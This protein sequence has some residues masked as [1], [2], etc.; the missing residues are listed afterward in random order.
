[1]VHSWPN[2]LFHAF[3][4]IE[5]GGYR[6]IFPVRRFVC[7]AVVA[8]PQFVHTSRSLWAM[9]DRPRPV[10]RRLERYWETQWG[11]K[12]NVPLEPDVPLRPNVCEKPT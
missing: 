1:M 12:R 8:D 4:P 11:P 2:D 6:Q 3:G 10:P 7:V 9:V 5:I